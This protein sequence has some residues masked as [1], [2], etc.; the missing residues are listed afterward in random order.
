MDLKLCQEILCICIS[1]TLNQIQVNKGNIISKRLLSLKSNQTLIEQNTDL[2][3]RLESQL[4]E[5]FHLLILKA[6]SLKENFVLKQ[7]LL[8][9]TCIGGCLDLVLAAHD[10]SYSV[11]KSHKI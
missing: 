6:L 9:I 4:S 11:S 10:P 8:S 5:E 1:K 7:S 2:V 3:V